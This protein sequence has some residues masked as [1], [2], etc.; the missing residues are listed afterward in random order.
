ME[1]V[2]LWFKYVHLDPVPPLQ[3]LRNEL[4]QPTGSKL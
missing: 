4:Q 2:V 3:W 1:S